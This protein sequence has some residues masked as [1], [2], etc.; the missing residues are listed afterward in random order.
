MFEV[1][2]DEGRETGDQACLGC[3]RYVLARRRKR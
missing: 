3:D 1:L 2:D